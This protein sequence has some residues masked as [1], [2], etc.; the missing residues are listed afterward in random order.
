MRKR[1]FEVGLAP[2][3]AVAMVELL[4]EEID[5]ASGEKSDDVEPK[6]PNEEDDQ[7]GNPDEGPKTG[8]VGF[9]K[10]SLLSC[11]CKRAGYCEV[12]GSFAGLFETQRLTL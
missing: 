11:K 2:P 12:P 6:V 7:T 3:I 8:G 1:W 10:R 5:S 9:Q 4:D